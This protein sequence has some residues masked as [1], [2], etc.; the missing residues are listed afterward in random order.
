MASVLNF[1][2]LVIV[3]ITIKMPTFASANSVCYSLSGEHVQDVQSS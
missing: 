3:I 1:A 2:L